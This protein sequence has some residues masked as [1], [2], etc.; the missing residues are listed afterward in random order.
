MGGIGRGHVSNHERPRAMCQR[1]THHR[2]PRGSP[3]TVSRYKIA[4]LTNSID[5]TLL[6]EAFA[7]SL[8]EGT[9]DLAETEAGK[10]LTDSVLR[11]L[12]PAG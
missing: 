5:D 10:N 3:T 1:L 8:K 9:Q 6:R 12:S 7:T 2:P 4:C 11:C